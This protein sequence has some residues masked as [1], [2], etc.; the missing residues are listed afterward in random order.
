MSLN[1]ALS[2]SRLLKV[3]RDDNRACVKSPVFHCKIIY[4]VSFVN[5]S[6]S[7]NGVTLKTEG[8]FKTN[9]NM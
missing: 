9:E 7:K 6:S 5:Y 8:K 1:I 3:I 2:H 4:H